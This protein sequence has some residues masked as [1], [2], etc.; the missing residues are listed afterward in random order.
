MFANKEQPIATTGVGV[1]AAM[2][3][4]KLMSET[5]TRTKA[6]IYHSPIP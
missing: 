1:D 4:L 5:T 2:P 6:I 3:H